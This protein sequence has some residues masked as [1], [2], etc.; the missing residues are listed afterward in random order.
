M[1]TALCTGSS[2]FVGR[3]LVPRLEAEGYEVL[4]QEKGDAC[5]W[6]GLV[7]SHRIYDVVVHL[8]ANILDVDTRSKAGIA[9]YQDI[10]LDLDMVEYLAAYP[11]RQAAILMSSCAIDAADTDPYAFIKVALEQFAKAL[12]RQGVPVK[13]LRP[14][15]GYGPGQALS[16]PFPA[17]L[18]RAMRREDP[19]TVWG[20]AQVRDW[21]YIDDLLDAI[22]WAVEGAPTGVPIEIGTGRGTSIEALARRIAWEAGYV[23][24]I[25]G[26]QTKEVSSMRR[27]ADT[28]MAESLGWKAKTSLEEGI[29]RCVEAAVGVQAPTI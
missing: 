4:C 2:G 17:I 6:E 5:S 1:K 27:V 15:S 16:Y 20:G 12:H 26:D 8:A 14:F 7:K 13:I 9:S 24:N 10:R 11:P 25:A 3:H 28:R 18:D 29:K 22:L 21:L 23:P 19:L